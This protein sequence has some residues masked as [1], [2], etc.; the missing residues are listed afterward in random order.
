MNNRRLRPVW[1]AAAIG[2]ILGTPRTKTYHL[3]EQGLITVARKVGAT[4]QSTEGELEDFLL[5]R[6]SAPPREAAPQPSSPPALAPKLRR[7]APS[8]AEGR[9]AVAPVT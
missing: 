6:V 9:R 7:R 1:G 2:K 3:L 4:W 8:A 5:G